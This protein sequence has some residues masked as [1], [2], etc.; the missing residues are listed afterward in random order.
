MLTM[1]NIKHHKEQEK[2]ILKYHETHNATP[3][4]LFTYFVY[5]LSERV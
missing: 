2:H 4:C 5:I 3:H 1:L